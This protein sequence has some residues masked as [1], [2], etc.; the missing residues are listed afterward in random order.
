MA[1]TG[2]QKR[3]WLAL[4]L[5]GP[6]LLGP[7]RW[8][9]GADAEE[10]Q[11]PIRPGSLSRPT[12]VAVGVYLL[13][14]F[15]VDD[16]SQTITVDFVLWA[17]WLDERIASDRAGRRQFRL[18]EV[19]SPR[20][21]VVNERSLERRLPEVV[22]VD[23]ENRVLYAQRFSGTIAST[24]DLAD[25]PFDQQLFR[26]YVIAGG[27]TREEV[28]LVI[29]PD[30][31]GRSQR[32]SVIDW[33]IGAVTA[34]LSPF[35]YTA[36]GRVFPGCAF[37]FSAKRHSGYYLWKVMLPLFI[38]VFMSWSV[39]WIDPTAAPAQIGVA[40]TSILALIAYQFVLGDLVPRLSYL[41]RQDR[42][43]VGS[44]VLVFAALVEVI[45]TSTLASQG[46]LP[47]AKRVD[48]WSRI[49]F[50]AVFLLLVVLAF[51]L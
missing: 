44:T 41:T 32:L 2:W 39:F 28:E 35:E 21:I 15:D 23:A 26:I 46:N 18:S 51:R 43:L 20:L 6:L 50:P 13:D 25:F 29:E 11:A 19:W 7:A 45:A 4:A 10:Q 36:D 12:P 16:A 5:A 3:G 24:S 17:R 9:I 40:A 48:R 38:V 14:V 27:Y 1:R 22:V 47:L 30:R 49:V 34:E 31:T 37:A 42:F 8:G 33:E